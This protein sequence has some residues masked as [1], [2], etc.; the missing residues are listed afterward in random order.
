MQRGVVGLGRRFAI[1]K[2][3][4]TNFPRD[5]LEPSVGA[6]MARKASPTEDPAQS[7]SRNWQEQEITDAEVT[8]LTDRSGQADLQF[9]EVGVD[10]LQRLM[11][12]HSQ[13][14]DA[15]VHEVAR[16]V[17]QQDGFALYK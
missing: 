7:V 4:T 15:V 2:Q 10:R 17:L 5:V 16:T 9:L 3:I 1:D 12:A 13:R 8:T 14:G 11:K 6:P